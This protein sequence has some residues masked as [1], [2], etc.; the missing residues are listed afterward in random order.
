MS[1]LV[2]ELLSLSKAGLKPADIR[3][4]PVDLL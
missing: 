3:R 1:Q 2:N 4:I